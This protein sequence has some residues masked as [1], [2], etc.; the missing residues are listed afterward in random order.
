[1]SENR[2]GIGGAGSASGEGAG[3]PRRGVLPTVL[4]FAFCDQIIQDT[5]TGKL[6]LIGLYDRVNCAHFPMRHHISVFLS[7]IG[8][9]GYYDLENRLVQLETNESWN[10]G[11]G[12]FVIQD[13]LT[14]LAW[15]AQLVLDLPK[16]GWYAI[17]TYVRS[18]LLVSRRL[19]VVL[20]PLPSPEHA[21]QDLPGPGS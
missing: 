3:A 1:V 17:E 15:E 20:Q 12:W 7:V 16:P 10:L 2:G 4:N 6:S 13:P 8:G 18:T 5:K 21:E 19:R 11:K 14:P 9:H